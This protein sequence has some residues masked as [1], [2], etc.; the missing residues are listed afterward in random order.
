MLSFPLCGTMTIMGSNDI[1]S[2]YRYGVQG[3]SEDVSQQL[4]EE[5]QLLVITRLHQA[6]PCLGAVATA[7]VHRSNL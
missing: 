6:S 2:V 3:Q 4:N 5:E 1:H 7:C